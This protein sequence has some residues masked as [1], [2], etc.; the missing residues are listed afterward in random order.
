MKNLPVAVPE[1]RDAASI[2]R[3]LE[4]GDAWSALYLPG[5][6]AADYRAVCSLADAIAQ[7]IGE[8]PCYV[9][10]EQDMA[11]ALGH[12]L[13]L[14]LP[15]HVPIVCLDG[16]HIPKQSYLDIGNPVGPAVS[17]VIKTLAFENH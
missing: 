1:T 11:K 16:L 17:V 9:A 3:A 8:K 5:D 7:A 6:G 15:E 2:R 10:L 14:R 4:S 13:A 12:A